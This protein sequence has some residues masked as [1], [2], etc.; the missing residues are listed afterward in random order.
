[1]TGVS[2]DL[3][4]FEYGGWIGNLEVCFVCIITI[5]RLVPSETETFVSDNFPVLLFFS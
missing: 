3:R 4:F 5:Y 2:L 1:M